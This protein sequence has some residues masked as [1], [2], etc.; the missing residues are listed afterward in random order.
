MAD[1]PK[2]GFSESSDA[3]TLTLIDESTLDNPIGNYTRKVEL[4]TA[5]D[6]TGTKITELNFS[7]S[8]LEVEYSKSADQY[9][10]IVLIHSGSPSVANAINNFTTERYEQNL[11]NNRLNANCGCSQIKG[12]NSLVLGFI[13]MTQAQVATQYGNSGLANAFIQSSY[14]HLNS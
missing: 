5:K 12:C 3:K 2:V 7:G 11:T 10:S 1:F 13:Y 8:S 9:F 4:W 6:G 14:K